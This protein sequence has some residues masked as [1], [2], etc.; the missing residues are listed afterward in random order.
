MSESTSKD[1]FLLL[2]SKLRARNILS[3]DDERLIGREG[4][5]SRRFVLRQL[6]LPKSLE[7]G[8]DLKKIFSEFSGGEELRKSCCS[9]LDVSWSVMKLLL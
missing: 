1:E 7:H 5:S 3:E 6:L 2:C 9:Y 8:D 4:P